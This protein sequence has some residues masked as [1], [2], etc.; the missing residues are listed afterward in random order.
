MLKK[1]CFW[2]NLA[3]ILF[4]LELYYLIR[5]KKNTI[6]IKI[7]ISKTLVILIY[8]CIWK[9]QLYI[10]KLLNYWKGYFIYLSQNI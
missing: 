2:F 6:C 5:Y 4:I 10:N 8:N 7:Y 9:F 3:N 1:I